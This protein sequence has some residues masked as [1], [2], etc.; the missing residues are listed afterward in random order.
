MALPHSGAER[1]ANAARL[2]GPLRI[3]S[4]AV[5]KLVDAA[6]FRG[7]CYRAANWIHVGQTTGRGAW[8]ASTTT[9]FN[10]SKT[11]ISIFRTYSRKAEYFM[12]ATAI[13]QKWL[14][15]GSQIC[16]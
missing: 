1:A 11:S 9:I 16:E 4:T 3:S 14:Y 2:A 12:V 10:R 5:G 6:R 8:T 7:T 15:L 13:S